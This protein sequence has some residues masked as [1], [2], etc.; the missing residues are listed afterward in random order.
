MNSRTGWV[1]DEGMLAFSVNLFISYIYLKLPHAAFLDSSLNIGP[2]FPVRPLLLSRLEKSGA[3]VALGDT[4]SRL[5]REISRK[6][7]L[8]ASRL[9]PVGRLSLCSTGE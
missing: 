6:Q 2:T 5:A 7:A 1:S 8:V 3:F 4:G 9:S